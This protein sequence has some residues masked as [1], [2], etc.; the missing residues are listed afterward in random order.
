M[1]VK[2]YKKT[3]SRRLTVAMVTS[4]RHSFLLGPSHMAFHLLLELQARLLHCETWFIWLWPSRLG[5]HGNTSH[6]RSRNGMWSQW[7]YIVKSSCTVHSY[8]S[9]QHANRPVLTS[10][11]VIHENKIPRKLDT[12]VHGNQIP[13]KLD[14]LS[15][16]QK[17]IYMYAMPC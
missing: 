4:Y 1:S 3:R 7:V 6:W 16:A 9:H 13:W 10:T 11:L 8:H 12:N 17:G 2:C 14:S 15:D 5:F